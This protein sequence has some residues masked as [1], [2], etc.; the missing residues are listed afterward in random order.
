MVKPRHIQWMSGFVGSALLLSGA[1]TVWAAGK[2]TKKEE[3]VIAT[4]TELTK[5]KDPTKKREEKKKPDLTASDVFGG[6]GEELKSVTDSQIK[7]LQRL[8][9]ASGDDDPE[10]PDYL[11]R[12]AELFAEQERYYSFKARELDEKVFDA[13]QASKVAE[14][15]RLKAI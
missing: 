7:L 14:A 9:D 6:M 10:K 4:Q 11:F 13:Q 5:P 15:T 8:I 12:M 1:P 3:A 2:F